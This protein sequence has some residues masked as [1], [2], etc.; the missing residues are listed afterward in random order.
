MP[1]FNYIA[2]SP[3]G[4]KTKGILEADNERHVRKQ[5]RDNHMVSLSIE[6]S[7]GKNSHLVSAK[8]NKT[9][10]FQKNISTKDLALFTR[11]LATLIQA[12]LPLDEA[13]TAVSE[14][15][16][17][18]SSK[19]IILAVRN[20]VLEGKTLSESFAL[21]PRVF[22]TLFCSMVASGESSGDL[23]EV[24]IRLAEYI[25]KRQQLKQRALIALLY[26]GILSVVAIAIV[27]ALLAFVVP[28]IIS[29][30]NT[31]NQNL[32]L[33]TQW[34]IFISDTIKNDGLYILLTIL[35][36][37]ILIKM[38]IRN[39]IL[40]YKIHHFLLYLPGLGKVVLGLNIARFTRTLSILLSSGVPLLEALHIS[41]RVLN[42]LCLQAAIKNAAEQVHEG[43]SLNRALADTAYFPPIMI[44]M[45]A[46]GEKSGELS[47]MLE[48][49][50]DN[51]DKE[52]EMLMAMAL[53]LFEPILILVMG[54][55]VL[56][57]VS[58]VLLPIFELNTLI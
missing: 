33:A 48:R 52:F 5:L 46:N 2:L 40:K 16:Q 6:Q 11:Q 35:L 22:D 24:L 36:P 39:E 14:Q 8:A 32:P 1:V 47:Q 37:I 54:A 30:F 43:H 28:K 34:L 20:G 12:G 21:Y 3:E 4:K 25:E 42:N 19:S 41:A 17:K 55:I 44:Y 58:A 50:A 56:F 10:L 18:A 53:G 49:V 9:F 51:Q 29:Q 13:L 15:T 31:L 38:A 57:I 27:A 26:P 7:H 45:I 23:G